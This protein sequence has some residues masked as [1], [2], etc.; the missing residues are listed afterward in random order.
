MNRSALLSLTVLAFASCSSMADQ[1][2][3]ESP[4]AKEFAAPTVITTARMRLEPLQ[5]KFNELDY[6]AAQGSRDHL[7]TTLQW[8][9]WPSAE[10]TA[11]QNLGD[12]QRHWREF[13]AREAYAYTVLQP[14][15]EPCIGCVYLNPDKQNPRGLRMAYW[16]TQDQLEGG[17]DEHLVA[18]VLDTI[19]ASWPVDQVTISHPTQNPR[20]IAILER[21]GLA[22]L[23]ENDG[24]L[25][26]TWK[27]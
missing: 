4:W 26:F 20:G 8:G 12:L 10:M 23:G 13:T 25:A 21:L 2:A 7:R 17:L 1:R 15:G 19:A 27:R 5:P 24:Q 22:K 9:S 11:A 18:T 3:V 6:A 16:V 14:V